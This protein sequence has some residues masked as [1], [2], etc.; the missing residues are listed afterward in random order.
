MPD[1]TASLADKLNV[2][3]MIMYVEYLLRVVACN[4][5][6]LQLRGIHQQCQEEKC[7]L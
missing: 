2:M 4:S 7:H 5:W 6:D 1:I 3:T